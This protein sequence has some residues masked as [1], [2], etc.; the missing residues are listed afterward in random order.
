MKTLATI[1]TSYGDIIKIPAD[2]NGNPRY[3]INAQV[4][5]SMNLS[6]YINN[7]KYRRHVWLRKVKNGY[8]FSTYN[9]HDYLLY[10]KET[11]ERLARE[12]E[13]KKYYISYLIARD[14]SNHFEII[15]ELFSKD[16]TDAHVFR[17]E[18]Q[19]LREE[20]QSAYRTYSDFSWRVKSNLPKSLRASA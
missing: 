18:R 7:N 9:V 16:Y 12:D 17:K 11:I 13:E 5:V 15:D 3:F 14:E 1:P 6:E 20:Y 19:R 10:I 2:I 8:T 4:I